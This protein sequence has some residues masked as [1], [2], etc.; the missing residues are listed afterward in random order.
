MAYGKDAVNI[1]SVKAKR[2]RWIKHRS[3]LGSKIVEPKVDA[4]SVE[5]KAKAATKK[6][7]KKSSE[8]SAN[9][10]K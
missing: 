6:K 7:A 4:K 10:K 3:G 9:T 5:K 8:K 2:A 1:K